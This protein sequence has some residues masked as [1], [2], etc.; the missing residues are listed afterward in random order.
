MM[1]RLYVVVPWAPGAVTLYCDPTEPSGRLEGAL[2][3]L[4]GASSEAR[5]RALDPL[6]RPG[7]DPLL[8]SLSERLARYLAG[9]A[10]TF[11][12]EELALE[13][14]GPFQTA[15]LRAEHA[16]P[17]GSLSTYGRVAA[18]IGHPRAARA[19]GTALGSNPFPILIPCHRA[20]RSD[21]SLGGYAGGLEMKRILL[22]LEGV[23]LE[24]DGRAPTDRFVY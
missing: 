1:T 11:P 5:M 4:P 3:T 21:G 18:H 10:I 13:R 19:V 24:P 17:R 7:S 8:D 2:L 15:V 12:L 22:A 20:V 9:E 14:C 6:A 16:I 23:T